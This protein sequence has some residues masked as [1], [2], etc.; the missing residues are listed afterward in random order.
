MLFDFVKIKKN[1]VVVVMPREIY[2]Y[3][4][5]TADNSADKNSLCVEKQS[6]AYR[7]GY[8]FVHISKI[9]AYFQ[10]QCLRE[11]KCAYF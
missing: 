10:G 9:H 1:V 5:G 3:C 7:Q 4:T 8:H 6:M 11:R 2:G